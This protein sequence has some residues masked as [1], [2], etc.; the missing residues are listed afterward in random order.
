MSFLN[1]L[2]F[3]VRSLDRSKGLVITV[4]LTLALGIGA[5]AAIFTLVR[6]VLLRPLVNRDENRLIYIRQSAPGDG[7]R[8]TPL[9]P[10]RRFRILRSSVKTLSELGDFSHH[11]IHDGGPG[12]AA[13]SAGGGGERLLLR[14]D[15]AAAGAGPAAGYAG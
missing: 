12:R 3:A 13:R 8:T 5:N 10:C 15:G 11:R 6:G 1:D 9:S 4:V 14:G 7:R 2:K